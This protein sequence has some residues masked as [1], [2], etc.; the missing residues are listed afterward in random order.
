V[1]E[2]ALVFLEPGVESGPLEAYGAA[3]PVHGGIE[4]DRGGV[5]PVDV[6]DAQS[7]DVD[8]AAR[9]VLAVVLRGEQVGVD[10]D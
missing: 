5:R 6:A 4:E 9:A 2:D 8:G 1:D 3:E 7:V 10:V